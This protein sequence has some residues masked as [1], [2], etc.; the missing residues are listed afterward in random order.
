ME[1]IERALAAELS[2]ARPARGLAR[3]AVDLVDDAGGRGTVRGWASELGVTDRHL[4]NLLTHHVGLSPKR[5][6]RVTRANRTLR[7]AERRRRAGRLDWA[8]LAQESGYYDQSHL[9]DD[10]R[11]LMGESPEAFLAREN[12][13]PSR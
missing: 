10:F 12:R 4:R 13:E 6:A 9:I 1:L 11:E 7:R 5:Y 2:E 8:E 3:R